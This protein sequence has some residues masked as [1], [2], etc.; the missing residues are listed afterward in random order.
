MYIN[1]HIYIYTCASYSGGGVSAVMI[2]W[3]AS[4]PTHGKK[5]QTCTPP[6]LAYPEP[7]TAVAEDVGDGRW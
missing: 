4:T 7:R 2:R 1:I 5:I 6:R 3:Y